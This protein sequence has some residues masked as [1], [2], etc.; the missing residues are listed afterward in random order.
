[1]TIGG[2]GR[3][4]LADGPEAPEGPLL[5]SDTV[6]GAVFS[7]CLRRMVLGLRP[8][9]ARPDPGLQVADLVRVRGS[10]GGILRRGWVRRTAWISK[11]ASGSP[12]TTAGPDCPPCR[13]DSR[14]SN[15]RPFL[16]RVGVTGKSSS[17][18]AADECAPRRNPRDSPMQAV[19]APKATGPRPM[20]LPVEVSRCLKCLT[21]SRPGQEYRR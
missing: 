21:S 17:G 3:R 1:M 14:E 4:R 9:G 18:P 16:R 20:L 19:P 10:W 7:L 5:G 12:G 15:R 8:E 11:L 6:G 13:I 2:S